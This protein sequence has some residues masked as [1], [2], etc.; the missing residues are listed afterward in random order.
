MPERRT[1]P[2][3]ATPLLARIKSVGK[4]T[5]HYQVRCQLPR[6]PPQVRPL[7]LHHIRHDTCPETACLQLLDTPRCELGGKLRYLVTR[8]TILMNYTCS[9][10]ALLALHFSSPILLQLAAIVQASKCFTRF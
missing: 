10:P 1:I 2:T 8:K 9:D 5:L 4:H 3:T 6:Y 7:W